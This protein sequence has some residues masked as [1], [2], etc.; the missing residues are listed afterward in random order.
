MS[1]N[2]YYLLQ[3]STRQNIAELLSSISIVGAH[4]F[5]M[6]GANFGGQ[7]VT[8]HSDDIF[9]ATCNALWYIAPLS[10]QKIFLFLMHR[11]MKSFKP[12]LC[13]LFVASLE[14]F[15][16]LITTSLSYLTILYSIQ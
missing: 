4:F 8:D 14:G 16:T 1:I 3:P 12:V 15:A 13:N 6:F 2:L 5:Y 10:S 9:N 7:I 11:T